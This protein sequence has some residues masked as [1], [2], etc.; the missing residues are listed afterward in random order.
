[1]GVSFRYTFFYKYTM[2]KR[3]M[4]TGIVYKIT[5]SA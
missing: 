2:P 1:M 3:P 4:Y 5:A